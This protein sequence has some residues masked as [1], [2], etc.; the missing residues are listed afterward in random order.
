MV[1]STQH[2]LKR[3]SLG[4]YRYSQIIFFTIFVHFYSAF[5]EKSFRKIIFNEID[6]PNAKLKPD[7]VEEHTNIELKGW[8]EC[9]VLKVEKIRCPF[10]KNDSLQYYL[11]STSI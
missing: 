4:C 5:L 8:L 6:V 11:F 10:P 1:K 3:S 2:A 7:K 9:V